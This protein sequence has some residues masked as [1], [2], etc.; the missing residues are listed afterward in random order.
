MTQRYEAQSNHYLYSK[1][2]ENQGPIAMSVAI[3]MDM[4]NSS[5]SPDKLRCHETLQATLSPEPTLHLSS[6]LVSSRSSHLH[7]S[8]SIGKD[9][10][11]TKNNSI[12]TAKAGQNIQGVLSSL[13]SVV[14]VDNQNVEKRHETISTLDPLA[15]L[16]SIASQIASKHES[17]PSNVS[18]FNNLTRSQIGGVGN[19]D[20][21][22]GRGGLTNHHP[23]NIR[24]RSLVRRFQPDYLKA[25]KRNKAGIAHEIVAIIRTLS[26]S[27]RFLKKDSKDPHAWIDIGDRKAREKTSQALREGAPNLRDKKG[28][29]IKL[30]KEPAWLTTS[31][32]QQCANGS[33]MVN[34]N[35]ASRSFR[36]QET[37]SV[38][39]KNVSSSNGPRLK[40][41]KSKIMDCA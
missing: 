38:L 14:S 24:F 36:F 26:P 9:K 2:S 32:P 4:N 16:A 21:L 35:D 37:Y 40:Y 15:Q 12:V 7:L 5:P 39:N 29:E 18:A 23:G 41:L 11:G 10:K 30:N 6:N 25:S 34:L 13:K 33:K 28:K 27:G 17:I 3:K 31:Q 8:P 1:S 19:N 22:C 20:V